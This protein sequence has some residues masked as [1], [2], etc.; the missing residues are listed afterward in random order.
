MTTVA[1]DPVN[2]AI[3]AMLEGIAVKDAA[4][5]DA[6]RQEIKIKGLSWAARE[7]VLLRADLARARRERA[8]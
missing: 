2:D 8:A 7:I 5:H 1:R 3:I 4:A 6:V